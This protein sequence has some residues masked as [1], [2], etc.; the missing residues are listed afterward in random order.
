MINN[1]INFLILLFAKINLVNSME[2]AINTGKKLQINPAIANTYLFKKMEFER[3]KYYIG[4][5]LYLLQNKNILNEI[6]KKID[7]DKEEKQNIYN[8][9]SENE[10]HMKTPKIKQ[11]ATLFRRKK[12]NKE[13][14]DKFNKLKNSMFKLFTTVLQRIKI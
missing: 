13:N 1:K 9:V 5:Q 7:Q 14:K 11:D 4:K 12:I 10:K 8:Y 6:D 2:S 3:N